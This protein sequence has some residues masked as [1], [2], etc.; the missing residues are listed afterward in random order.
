MKEIILKKFP[1]Q[2]YT[3]IELFLSVLNRMKQKIE[4]NDSL[5]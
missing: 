3:L 2:I 4:L 1:F 5:K